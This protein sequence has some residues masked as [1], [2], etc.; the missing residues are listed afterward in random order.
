MHSR[1][2]RDLG[3][4]V[5]RLM[6]AIEIHLF[7]S[8]EV[9]GPTGR[10]TVCDF[11]SRKSKQVGELLALA[12]GRPVSKERLIDLLWS[13]RV[14]RDPNATVEHAV[15]LLR[16]TLGTVVD[17][18]TIVTER[19]RYRFDQQQIEIDL[20][21]FDELAQ[22]AERSLGLDRLEALRNAAALA[23]GDVLEDE[24]TAP[25]AEVERDRYR[26]CLERA[27]LGIAQLALAHDDAEVAHEAAERARLAS[28]PVLEEAYAL[29]ISALVRLGRRHE[30]RS[31]MRELERRLADEEASEP[32]AQTAALRVL[33][34][35]T[36]RRVSAGVTTPVMTMLDFS[37]S[38]LPADELPFIGRHDAVATIEGAIK[39]A[40]IGDNELVMVEGGPGIGKSRLL[41][42]IAERRRNLP[43]DHHTHQFS[44][45]PSDHGHP[46]LAVGRLLRGLARAARMRSTPTIDLE[47]A[48]MFGRLADVFDRLGP[49]VLLIDDVHLADRASLDVLRSLVAPGAVRSLCVVGARRP[50]APDADPQP[51]GTPTRI[52]HLRS[53]TEDDLKALG[54]AG[55]WA[56]TGGH[57]ASLAACLR[58]SRQGGI[59]DPDDVAH[60]L[61]LVDDCGEL[62]RMVLELAATLEPPM[63]IAELARRSRLALETTADL[64]E[65]A[66]RLELVR[67]DGGKG[68]A[69]AG[70]L[71]RRMLRST[72]TPH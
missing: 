72:A 49:T 19:G 66:V 22:D 39:R 20:V 67:A 35:P 1:T 52:V 24:P 48:P 58:A 6:P 21:R 70:D 16:A 41:T 25:W 29:D 55:A 18:P 57:P 2:D 32:S 30:A 54:L 61:A 38:D 42:E 28:D 45:Q 33:L 65:R 8:F 9:V 50:L 68:V 11:P 51:D 36:P 23:T 17:S 47:V 3:L 46:M 40:S 10:L 43:T 69:F 53:L 4:R 26:R 15:S 5:T 64:L 63:E 31:L 62:T 27:V 59:L 14:P 37:A 60:L 12:R 71:T 13:D 34:R 56:E 44:C 7:G